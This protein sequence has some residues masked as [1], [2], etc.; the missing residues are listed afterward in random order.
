MAFLLHSTFCV[1]VDKAPALSEDGQRAYPET[2]LYR[3][4][5]PIADVVGAIANLAPVYTQ[6]QDFQLGPSHLSM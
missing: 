2:R 6:D 5:S 3:H 1:Q 4:L